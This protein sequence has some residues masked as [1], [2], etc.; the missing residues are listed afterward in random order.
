ML[1]EASDRWRDAR[2]YLPSSLFPRLAR[3][4]GRL[5]SLRTL[6]VYPVQINHDTEENMIIDAFQ[7]APLLNVVRTFETGVTFL[8]PSEQLTTYRSTSHDLS[9][10][11]DG[12]HHMRNLVICHIEIS[13][14]FEFLPPT[15]INLP[16]LH[17]LRITT[18]MSADP[19]TL[20][21]LLDAFTAP[22]LAELRIRSR[23]RAVSHLIA[24][25]LRSSC[26]LRTL[27][28]E[29]YRI[30]SNILRFLEHTPGLTDLAL[31]ATRITSGV[32]R[33]LT[34]IVESTLDS[35]L[36]PKLQ[37]LVIDA[38]FPVRKVLD[39]LRSRTDYHLFREGVSDALSLDRLVIGKHAQMHV[40]VLD[41]LCGMR[42]R[43][44]TVDMLDECCD[45]RWFTWLYD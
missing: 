33:G 13:E 43:G 32:A 45:E 1:M 37:T 28:M 18:Y 15:Q 34:R 30:R 23:Q 22:K 40:R 16:N 11:S 9:L 38:T 20:A 25:V 29:T 6:E 39:M 19:G 36:L 24:L 35:E 14:D 21:A 7:R 10:L 26:S 44:L 31:K 3:I 8:I 41:A 4:K 42:E 17:T 12:L 5:G 27:S 2:L